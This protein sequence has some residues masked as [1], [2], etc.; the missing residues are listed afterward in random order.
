MI[1]PQD[2]DPSRSALRILHEALVTARLKLIIFDLPAPSQSPFPQTLAK[3]MPLKA[4]ANIQ[5]EPWVGDPIRLS[6]LLYQQS[7]SILI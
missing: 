3:A 4:A 6:Y 2:E 7:I 5:P 1:H